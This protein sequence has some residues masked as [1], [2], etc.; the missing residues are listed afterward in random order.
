MR[1]IPLAASAAVL[2]ALLLVLTACGPGTPEPTK[3]PKPSASPTASATPTPTPE[4]APVAA[5]CENIVSPATIAGFAAVG[6]QITPPADFHAK[7]ASEGNAMAVFFDVGGVLCQTGQ[8][9]GA[10]EIYGYGILSAA[11]FAPVRNQFVSEGYMEVEGDSGVGYEVPSD[12][13]GLPRYCY[14]RVDEFTV[15]GNDDVRVS[16]I[17]S[18]LGLS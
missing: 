18:T 13:E 12:M 2:T 7:L 17:M 8:G 3:T 16:E 1:R 9:F 4:P 15:C 11:Q 14:F 6:I 5:T 10:Y